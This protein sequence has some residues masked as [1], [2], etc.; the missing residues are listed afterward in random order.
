MN[1]ITIHIPDDRLVKLQETAT[2]LGVSIEELVLMGVEQ[3]LKQ[4]EVSFQDAMDYV[5]KK[6]AELYKRLA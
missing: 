3:L 1:T 2:R 5:L 6:N 4:P